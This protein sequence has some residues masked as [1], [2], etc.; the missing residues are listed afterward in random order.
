ML[1]PLLFLVFIDDIVHI[2]Q[3]CQIRL[4]ADDTCL[5]ITVDNR[6]EAAEM[7]NLDLANIEDWSREW[8]VNFSAPKTKS[9]II[10]NKHYTHE[11]P[12]LFLHNQEIKEV[13]QHKHLCVT[14]SS[15]LRWNAHLDDVVSKCTKKLDMMRALKF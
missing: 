2:I 11:H 7:I 8:L 10:S 1:G 12:R 4:F 3:N 5:F 6:A 15:N 9:L 13:S 14:L